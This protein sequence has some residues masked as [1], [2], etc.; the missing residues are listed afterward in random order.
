M[1]YAKAKLFFIMMSQVMDEKIKQRA[2]TAV[3]L[4]SSD[5]V[6]G[7]SGLYFSN[8]KPAKVNKKHISAK[9]KNSV[10]QN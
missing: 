6:K 10:W 8:R 9:T 3:C 7:L 5:D 4:A 1:V 2:D